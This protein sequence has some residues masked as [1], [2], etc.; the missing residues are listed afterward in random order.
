MACAHPPSS[1]APKRPPTVSESTLLLH[2]LLPILELGLTSPSYMRN[3]KSAMRNT[4]S[5]R[6]MGNSFHLYILRLHKARQKESQA[7]CRG[8]A[9]EV[10]HVTVRRSRHVWRLKCMIGNLGYVWGAWITKSP[11]W[12]SLCRMISR[13]CGTLW[14]MVTIHW[15]TL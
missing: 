2:Q 9:T 11:F 13:T 15:T 1:F 10:V 8:Q 7:T 5:S 6:T 4:F 12:S 14:L 3:Q